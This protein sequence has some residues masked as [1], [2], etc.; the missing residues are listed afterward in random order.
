M[1]GFLQVDPATVNADL[2]YLGLVVSMWFA[3]TAAYMPGTGIIEFFALA[4]LGVT[5]YILSQLSVSWFA[6]LVLMI[7]VSMFV[8]M[9]FIRVQYASLAVAGLG[10]QG[11]GGLLLFESGLDVS[12][13]VL[14]L[15]LLIPLAYH[16]LVLMPMLVNMRDR[17]VDEKDSN[18]VGMTGRVTKDFDPIGTVYVNSE[19]WSAMTEEEDSGIKVGDKVLVI[20]RE[21][22]RLIVEPVKRKRKPTEAE[23][24]E[25]V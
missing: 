9:P 2:L 15:S 16:Q 10:L 19:H 5:I 23:E 24:E 21:S 7:G 3:V 20:G 17:P 22:L 4:G 11:I 13:F 25:A 14:A 6:V 18:L 8:I 1:G 12:L